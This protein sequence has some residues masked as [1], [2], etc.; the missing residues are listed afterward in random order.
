MGVGDSDDGTT[1]SDEP[2]AVPGGTQATT[3]APAAPLPPPPG[4]S[5]PTPGTPLPPAGYSPNWLPN[6]GPPTW[7]PPRQPKPPPKPADVRRSALLI[8]AA[9][10]VGLVADLGLRGG[11]VSLGSAL[12]VTAVATGLMVVAPDR[13]PERWLWATLAVFAAAGLM[14]RSSPWIVALDWLAALAFLGLASSTR[15]DHPIL[16][17]SLPRL[18]ARGGAPVTTSFFLGPHELLQSV[19]TI[20]RRPKQEV[21]TPSVLRRTAPALARGLLLAVPILLVLGALLASADGVFASFFDVPTPDLGDPMSHFALVGLGALALAAFANWTHRPF[22]TPAPTSRPLGPVETIVVLAGL[23]ILY[24]LFA[25]AQVVAAA[26]GDERIQE[27]TGLTYAEYARTGF[28]QLLW[29]AAITIVILLG[30]RALSRP[31]SRPQQVAERVLSAATCALTLVVVGAAISRLGLYQDAY[32]LTML[33]LACVTFAWV[34]GLAFLLLGIRML[35]TSPRDWLPV[36]YLAV[37]VAALGWWNG[38]NPETTVVETNL[39]RATATGKLDVDYLDTMSN[40]AV[41]AILDGLDGVP[42][43]IAAEVRSRWCDRPSA[44][45]PAD[46]LYLRSEST[47]SSH[48][49]VGADGRVRN[50]SGWAA[51]NL[52][53]HNAADALQR[54]ATD[55][56]R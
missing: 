4:W 49:E 51:F 22:E 34:L 11:L 7:V 15:R 30:L 6:P 56:G 44:T 33:R 42:T 38:S 31:G 52:S 55:Y 26:G 28:F 37:V 20:R 21:G 47:G 10:V 24:G 29:C 1:A 23:T 53:R 9:G 40:D 5:G 27:T 3:A 18:A 36:A 8:V 48:L 35:Q 14:W 13:T 45:R 19:D 54:C 16:G 32:G 46:D 12:T 41:P 17:S 39:A 2:I 50:R 43:P 25:F